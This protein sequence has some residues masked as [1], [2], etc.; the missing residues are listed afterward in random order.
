M[1]ASDHDRES[2]AAIREGPT[3]YPDD[4]VDVT[5]ILWL[6]AM[7]PAERLDALQGAVDSIAQLGGG[8]A[9]A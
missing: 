4:G 3:G 5:L 7:P 8:S 6:L 1:E 2:L 9:A